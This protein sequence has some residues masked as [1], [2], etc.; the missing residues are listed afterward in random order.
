MNPH[1]TGGISGLTYFMVQKWD[2]RI[3]TKVYEDL[4]KLYVKKEIPKGWGDSL[5]APIPKVPD[6]TL[7]DLRPLMLFEVLRKIWTGLI[8][9][10]LRTYWV[11]WGLINENQHGFMGGKGTHTAIPILINCME[12]AKDFAT[13]LFISSW[14]IKRAFDSLGPEIVIKALIR[15]HVPRVLAEYLVNIDQSGEVYVRTPY[16]S[17]LLEKGLLLSEGKGFKRGKGVGQG[18]VPSPM[19]WVAVFDILLTALARIDSGFKV[20]DDEGMTTMVKDVAFADDLVSVT[21]TIEELQNKADVI[22]GW[23]LMTGI[24]I[25]TKKLRTFGIQWG[26]KKSVERHIVLT[27]GP[28]IRTTVEV[29]EDGI[30]THLGVVWNMD[31][32][33]KKQWEDVR[34]VIERMGEIIMRGK[35]RT[36]EKVIVLNYCLKATVLYRMQYCT[37]DLGKYKELDKVMNRVAK[38]ITKNMKSFPNDLINVEKEDGGLGIRSLCDEA[39]ERKLKLLTDWIDKD[40]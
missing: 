14:D 38:K 17:E 36:R 39:N 4:K 11:K 23:C 30:M 21:G 16:N 3:K 26:V 5:L 13:D 8:M 1:S 33:N 27:E 24:K 12:S 15:M 37:W 22:S 18:D 6:P 29:K 10:K 9:E 7:E 31:T 2:I 34:L 35:G 40:N 20:Q 19:L 25:A 32:H 28:G